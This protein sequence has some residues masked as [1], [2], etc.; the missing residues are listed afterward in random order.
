MS[1][2]EEG[3]SGDYRTTMQRD[4]HGRWIPIK[5]ERAMTTEKGKGGKT[6]L[7]RRGST[8]QEAFFGRVS[9]SEPVAW[10]IFISIGG[11]PTRY[12]GNNFRRNRGKRRRQQAQ[13]R[14][15]V[16]T[17]TRP[18]KRQSW[19]RTG[20]LEKRVSVRRENIWEITKNQRWRQRD[21]AQD[22]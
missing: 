20:P 6:K 22:L 18:R 2:T 10:L 17:P 13:A 14:T 7:L 1:M 5:G 9:R 16:R 21:L 8:E 12:R 19:R 15:T 4:H 11:T 3:P